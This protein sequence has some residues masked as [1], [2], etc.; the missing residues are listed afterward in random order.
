MSTT[1]PFERFAA[2]ERRRELIWSFTRDYTHENHHNPS[3]REIAE[4]VGVSQTAVK[5]DID[6]VLVPGGHMTYRPG[7][8]RS[9][10]VNENNP[11]HARVPELS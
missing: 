2:A 6:H 3:I 4:A 10:A 7:R 9:T 5:T 8:Q 1:D 11:F